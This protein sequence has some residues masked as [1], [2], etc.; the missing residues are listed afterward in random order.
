M[1]SKDTGVNIK[2]IYNT[3]DKLSTLRCLLMFVS[4][5]S[6]GE[7]TC[8]C[9][10]LRILCLADI[11]IHVPWCQDIRNLSFPI[12]SNEYRDAW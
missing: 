6:I 7:L 8:T 3:N 4:H 1:K 11:S 2:T 5:I 9:Y 12:Q 10:A